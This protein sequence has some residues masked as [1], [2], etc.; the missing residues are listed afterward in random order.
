MEGSSAAI[1]TGERAALVDES[2]V[3]CSGR[4]VEGR[5]A[6]HHKL[7]RRGFVGKNAGTSG[8]RTVAEDYLPAAAGSL[9]G[10]DKVL[11]NARIVRD[12]HAANGERQ[13]WARSDGVGIRCG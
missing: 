9:D 10:S 8:A 12:A 4:V 3:C 6:A 5:L 1:G 7:G 11:C 2:T 13:S